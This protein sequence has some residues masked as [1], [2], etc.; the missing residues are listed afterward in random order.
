M[1]EKDTTAAEIKLYESLA[2]KVIEK[3][4][5]NYIDAYFASDI[6]EGLSQVIRLIPQEASI[7]IG[8]SITL[9][10]IGF[11]DWLD[12]Q[13][14]FQVFNPFVR[15]DSGHFSHTRDERF[16]IMRKALTAD[17]YLASVNAVTLE[18]ELISVDGHGN[19]VAPTIFGP[20]K[21][22]LV[23]GANK[24]TKDR[25][26]ALARIRERCAPL[27]AIRHVE[28]HYSNHLRNLPCVKT[29][30]CSDCQ[31][32]ARICRKTM[33]ISGQSPRFFAKKEEGI[34]VVLIRR[35]LGI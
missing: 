34:S 33:I 19:R 12:Q 23:L 9:H 32:P 22:I 20:N 10:Q 25:E 16:D 18:G 17:V 3:L 2:K 30:L 11:F 21:V 6:D 24:I 28:K 15:T 26:A 35:Q 4:R 8:D 5:R 13:E 29:G 27:N 14:E 1:D 7:G 31:D